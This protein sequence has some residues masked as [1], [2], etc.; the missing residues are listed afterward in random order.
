MC[1]DSATGPRHE[2]KN[3][4]HCRV[5]GDEATRIAVGYP[6]NHAWGHRRASYAPSATSHFNSAYCY[7]VLFVL[8]ARFVVDDNTAGYPGS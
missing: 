2:W 1:S 6:I 4:D 8:D 5:L 3:E 7:S